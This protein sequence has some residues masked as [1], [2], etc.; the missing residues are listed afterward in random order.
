MCLSLDTYLYF[1]HSMSYATMEVSSRCPIC[2]DFYNEAVLAKD[3]FSYC[4]GCIVEW[5]EVYGSDRRWASP[6]TRELFSGHPVLRADVERNCVARELRR[7]QLVAS[8]EGDDS[9]ASEAL[10]ALDA[11]Q[12]G[13]PL[14]DSTHC[15]RILQQNHSV[16]YE[17]PYVFLAVAY[18][19]GSLDGLPSSFLRE[20]LRL[21]RHGVRVPLLKMSV[22]KAV[23]S[24][25]CKALMQGSRESYVEELVHQLEK[26]LFWRAGHRD[27]VEVPVDRILEKG[28]DKRDLAGFYYRDWVCAP[29]STLTFI[30]GNGVESLRRYLFVPLQSD[31]S[32]GAY[33]KPSVTRV[34]LSRQESELPSSQIRFASEE[35]MRE[36]ADY[37]RARRGGLPFPDSRGMSDTEEETEETPMLGGC[38]CLFEKPPLHLPIGF[39]YHTYVPCLE[40]L[41]ELNAI[42]LEALD[43]LG[44]T[45]PLQAVKR[46]RC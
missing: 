39:K 13:N 25:Y 5:A 11:S 37:W 38:D 35:P 45:P 46:Q 17:S 18:R 41:H 4:R 6:I 40:H 8:L 15:L 31:A 1:I 34:A 10:Q 2:C 3:G 24:H 20:V 42:R 30:T 23:F 44:W 9:D 43:A 14:L 36:D 33:E 32:R 7:A 21:D 27:A 22:V 28:E 12:E 26:H 16:L 19:A 29:E